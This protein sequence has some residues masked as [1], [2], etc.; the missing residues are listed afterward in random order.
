MVRWATQDMYRECLNRLGMDDPRCAEFLSRDVPNTPT[1]LRGRC[2]ATLCDD[3]DPPAGPGTVDWSHP[4]TVWPSAWGNR[5]APVG[6]SVVVQDLSRFLSRKSGSY[7]PVG[8]FLSTELRGLPRIVRWDCGLI[9]GIRPKGVY[10][11][12]HCVRAICPAKRTRTFRRKPIEAWPRAPRSSNSSTKCFRS[13]KCLRI[14]GT[15]R[16]TTKTIE[17]R[18]PAQAETCTRVCKSA[19]TTRTPVGAVTP[20][21]NNATSRMNRAPREVA[22][23]CRRPAQ[24]AVAASQMRADRQEEGA[25]AEP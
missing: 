1:T 13:A 9:A 8:G 18:P 25:A 14:V 19:R 2:G 17:A 6:R 5:G 7:L 20:T 23:I 3:G 22:E 12:Y 21:C 11:M 24:G 15:I 4:G 10:R 16:A